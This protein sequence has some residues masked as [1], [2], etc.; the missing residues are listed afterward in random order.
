MQ[1]IKIQFTNVKDIN[2]EIYKLGENS[3][4][5]KVFLD[6]K[7]FKLSMDTPALCHLLLFLI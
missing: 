6:W 1:M 5:S 7:W 3:V 4:L 2:N